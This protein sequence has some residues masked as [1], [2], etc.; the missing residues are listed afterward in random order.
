M[1]LEGCTSRPEQH[2]KWIPGVCEGV[3]GLPQ[4]TIHVEKEQC[5]A[6]LQGVPFMGGARFKVDKAH[7]PA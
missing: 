1:V 2:N 4:Q 3:W 5:Q 6:V 7:L